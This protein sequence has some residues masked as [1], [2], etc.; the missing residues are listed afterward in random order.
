MEDMS[1]YFGTYH[2]DNNAPQW[3]SPLPRLCP[4]SLRIVTQYRKARTLQTGITIE[5][6]RLEDL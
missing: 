2:S 6:F 4:G 3:D 1:W 5:N